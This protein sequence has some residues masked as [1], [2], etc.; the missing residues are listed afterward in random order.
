MMH[1][2]SHPSHHHMHPIHPSLQQ[3]HPQHMGQQIPPHHMPPN[4]TH[5]AAGAMH[6]FPRD[7]VNR[8]GHHSR[9]NHHQGLSNHG[10]GT[11]HQAGHQNPLLMG[12]PQHQVKQAHNNSSGQHHGV[13]GA[14]SS[15]I[16]SNNTKVSAQHHLPQAHH[17]KKHHQKTMHI[18]QNQ[19]SQSSQRLLQTVENKTSSTSSQNGPN[20][21]IV[22]AVSATTVSVPESKPKIEISGPE[23]DTT[24][25]TT[26][27]KPQSATSETLANIKEKTPMCLVNELARHNKIQHQ[28]RLTGEQGPAHK[29]K[30]TVILKLGEEEYTA[31]GPSIKKAQHSAA[32]EAISQTKYKHPPA[33]TNRTRGG[34]K[35]TENH[36]GNITPTVE[37]NALAMKRGEQTTYVTD[38]PP[39]GLN[40]VHQAPAPPPPYGQPNGEPYV[41]GDMGNIPVYNT[42]SNRGMFPH[43]QMSRYHG[44]YDKRPLGR[45]FPQRN[46]LI[47]GGHFG[48]NP[49]ALEQ[50]HVT[51]TVGEREFVGVGTTQQAARHDAAARALE[52]LKPITSDTVNPDTSLADDINSELKSPI[53]L[54]HEMALKRNLSVVFEVKTEKGPP[55]MKIFITIC[56]VGTLRTEGEGNGKKISKKRAAEAML[57]ELKKLPPLSPTQ[58]VLKLKKKPQD[59]VK[60][61]SRNLIKEKDD[62]E[63]QSEVNP[64]SKLIQIQ[65]SKKEK[66]PIYNLTEERGVPRRREFVIEVKASGYTAIGI[67][68]NKKVAK[69]LA[70]ENLL[71]LMGFGGK[72]K[73]N[74]DVCDA[75]TTLEKG[76]KVTFQEDTASSGKSSGGSAGRQ[77][78]PGLLLVKDGTKKT[79]QNGRMQSTVLNPQ[80]AALAKEFLAS[81]NSPPATDAK[82]DSQSVDSTSEITT[83]EVKAGNAT[84]GIRPK[85]QLLYLA[86]L[87]GFNAQF[88]DFPKGNH[89]EFLTL[90]TLS[91]HP[92]QLCH[93][94]GN[95]IEASHDQ[96]STKMLTMLSEL[97]LDNVRPVNAPS[98]EATA[99]TAP[100]DEK[101]AKPI[102]SNG[103]KK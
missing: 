98:T 96:A 93:G 29:K 63:Y 37:L 54:V 73:T 90:I 81:G 102:L 12:H 91:T 94:S 56:I 11:K 97:G 9:I 22:S 77:L 17:T 52:V 25:N 79:D 34:V 44:G 66:E 86:Q 100:L 38:Q 58:R 83:S 6:G 71:N 67:G 89:G 10:R 85:D 53:S 2:N 40:G 95:S 57:E 26:K 24:T 80:T 76:K 101:K 28:Y 49:P 35:A 99:S 75:A 23:D 70:A 39:K 72:E 74:G 59:V 18:S 5:P 43:Q 47:H 14:G 82:C 87:I 55:H 7:Q 1:H 20:I 45:G 61:K 27:E 36:V 30:F 64:I 103:L 62:P 41:Q 50:Y 32:S 84:D 69:R 51:L 60:K 42:Y 88:S 65:Q 15:G 16:S 19:N 4:M 48:G 78:V 3:Q 13:S 33:K 21:P 8:F 31:E 68:S 92:P 46:A